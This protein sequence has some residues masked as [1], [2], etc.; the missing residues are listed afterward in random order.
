MA[1][2]K[3]IQITAGEAIARVKAWYDERRLTGDHAIYEPTWTLSP[4][5]EA[6]QQRDAKE[7]RSLLSHL[8]TRD[9]AYVSSVWGPC[10]IEDGFKVTTSSWIFLGRKDAVAKGYF[11]VCPTDPT[12]CACGREVPTDLPPG[13]YNGPSVL[14]CIYRTNDAGRLLYDRNA[15]PELDITL[16]FADPERFGV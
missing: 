8:G 3:K 10:P 2:G 16:I 9:M 5:N 12:L 7:A 13:L 6:I 4:F 11:K 15:G 14:W 1:K